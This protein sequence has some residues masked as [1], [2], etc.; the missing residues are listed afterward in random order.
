[1]RFF[2][3]VPRKQV[4]HTAYFM[5]RQAVKKALPVYQVYWRSYVRVAANVKSVCGV[6]VFGML[7]LHFCFGADYCF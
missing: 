6:V 7:Q 1:M 4:K 2:I 3:E 5:L